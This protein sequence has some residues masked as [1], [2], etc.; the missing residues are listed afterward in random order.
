MAGQNHTK[1]ISKN[2]D[3]N[4]IKRQ[5]HVRDGKKQDIQIW[6]AQNSRDKDLK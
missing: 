2:E 4:A 3:G 5:E 6:N 1:T